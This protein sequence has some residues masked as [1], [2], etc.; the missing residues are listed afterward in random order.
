MLGENFSTLL[1][2]NPFI[3]LHSFPFR[4]NMGEHGGFSAVLPLFY[5]ILGDLL[6]TSNMNLKNDIVTELYKCARINFQRRNTVIKGINY[7]CQADPIQM[8]LYK[9]N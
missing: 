3:T 9:N 4:K 2:S 6:R 1:T 5:T 7:L 8:R